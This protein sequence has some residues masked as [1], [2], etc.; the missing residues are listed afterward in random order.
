MPPWRGSGS[1]TIDLYYQ[2]RVDPKVPIEETVGAMARARRRG[3]GPPPRALRGGAGD[4]PPR[5]RGAPDRRARD[6]VLAVDARA[7]RTRSCRP[8]AS[9]GIGFVAYS[10]LGRGFLTGRFRRPED[11][12]ADDSRRNHPRFQGENFD[13]QPRRWS[14][15]S[16]RSPP[17]R[18][19]SPGSSRSPGCCTAATTSSRSPAPRAATTSSRTWPRAEIELG[20]EDLARLDEAA[21]RGVRGGRSLP[22]HVLDRPLTAAPFRAMTGNRL[23]TK[24]E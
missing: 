23:P 16:A 18:A 21:P 2:H 8:C 20:A 7:S 22:G 6:R 14:I 5:P 1:S 4:D 17:R 15:G 10:P 13:A 24:Q 12:A 3:Q 11:L 19:S 9:S